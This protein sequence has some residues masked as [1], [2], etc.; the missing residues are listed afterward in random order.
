MILG[1]KLFWIINTVFN[2]FELSILLTY[3]V[4]SKQIEPIDLGRI[5]RKESI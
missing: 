5:N 4:D 1:C 3:S 2:R